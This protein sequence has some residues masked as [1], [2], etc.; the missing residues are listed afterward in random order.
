MEEMP[1]EEKSAPERVAPVTRLRLKEE[2][3]L[4]ESVAVDEELE[5]SLRWSL[6]E[7]H[8]TSAR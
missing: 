7:S 4:I 2:V 6:I 5:A 3:V 1:P 8:P